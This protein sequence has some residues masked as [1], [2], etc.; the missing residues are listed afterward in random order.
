MCLIN[1]FVLFTH[2]SYKHIHTR[3]A[4]LRFDAALPLNSI[5]VCVR[6]YVCACVCV[7][8]CVCVCG[9]VCMCVY[10]CV[11]DRIF[12]RVYVCAARAVRAWVSGSS[13]VTRFSAAHLGFVAVMA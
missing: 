7:C 1:A 12:V 11:C 6:V 10:V 4:Q 9:C 13:I 5:C 2:V 8:M 3:T